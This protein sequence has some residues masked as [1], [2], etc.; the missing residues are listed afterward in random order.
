MLVFNYFDARKLMLSGN[1]RMMPTCIIKHDAQKGWCTHDFY[2]I[3]LNRKFWFWR[4]TFAIHEFDPELIN[5]LD[6]EISSFAQFSI[7]LIK[8]YDHVSTLL[9]KASNYR[10]ISKLWTVRQDQMLNTNAQFSRWFRSVLV[11][12]IQLESQVFLIH[13]QT[14][15]SMYELNRHFLVGTWIIY[16]TR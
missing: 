10:I 13:S 6:C 2:E 1:P 12:I 5:I 9:L 7:K 16:D 4:E 14:T 8:K 11:S 15:H 3:E